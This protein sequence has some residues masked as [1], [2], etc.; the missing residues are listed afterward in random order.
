MQ[1]EKNKSKRLSG[2]ISS[3]VLLAISLSIVFLAAAVYITQKTFSEVTK[4]IEQLS[5][6]DAKTAFL[7]GVYNAFG[8][9]ER[10][11]QSRLL[12]DP[13]RAKD[14][15]FA[16]L[17]SL[18]FVIDSTSRQYH[19]GP[20]ERL[21]L[22]SISDMIER[23]NESLLKFRIMKRNQQPI[24]EQNLDSL[25]DLINSERVVSQSDVITTLKSTRILPT[26]TE[27][28]N[29]EEARD[30]QSQKT[31]LQ[32]IFS[33]GNEEIQPEIA[34]QNP[35]IIEETYIRIDTV[36]L[37]S[38]D[39]SIAKAGQLI[40]KIERK[41]ASRLRMINRV[42]MDIV[43]LGA[44][45]Q[46][47][48]LALIRNSEE[49]ELLRIH[50]ES[51]LANT[52]MQTAISRM[53]LVFGIFAILAILFVGRILNDLTKAKSYR[54]QLIEEKVRAENLSKIKERFLANM[55]HEIRTPLQNISGYS[56][57]LSKKQNSPD[58]EII[59]QS[60]NH[61]LQIVNQVLDFSRISTGNLI[62]HPKVFSITKLIDEVVSS[63]KIQAV[64]KNIRLISQTDCDEDRVYADPF[65]IRQILYNLLG[66]AIK[67]TGEGF[68]KLSAQSEKKG[69][70]IRVHFSIEDTGIG[71][72][73]NEIERL[74]K[75]FEQADTLTHAT[76][77]TGLGLSI[78]KA[79]VE[80][81]K[82]SIT[83]KS[84]E[85]RGTKFDVQLAL[86]TIPEVEMGDNN[87]KSIKKMR[88][89]LLVDDD[90]SILNLTRDILIENK[91]DVVCTTSPREAIEIAK[92]QT[93]DIALVDYRM[94]EMTG[95]ELC[96][97]L[98][99]IDPKMPVIAVTANPINPSG[100]T[101]DFDGYFPKPYR[102][103]E[104]LALLGY[105]DVDTEISDHKKVLDKK[106]ATITM[107]EKAAQE[108]LINQF[109][110]DSM[111]DVD[112]IENEL[113]ADNTEQ[114]RE[115]A[116]RIAGR[117]GF[118]E[119][120]NLASQFRQVEKAIED[121]SFTPGSKVKLQDAIK[122]LKSRIA[123]ME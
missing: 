2:S 101:T 111:N 92:N 93:F 14:S 59:H 56:E 77:G 87:S 82:G 24:L 100:E 9:F 34:Q 90:K 110:E 4:T 66:N 42:E 114:I 49:E 31:W 35:K 120:K 86:E 70:Q 80:E 1:I 28:Q 8:N 58:A 60:S 89:V 68:V 25:I 12:A 57:R 15:Y 48:I 6:A 118:F 18:K 122:E 88:R 21:I 50:T 102:T 95:A 16:S 37:A 30:D 121:N 78:V 47:F 41:Q 117:L 5:E 67:F 73:K 52:L 85:G 72:D 55:S 97:V 63:M 107:G 61:L 44:R 43:S 116:H 71:M 17:D 29:T 91:I 76:N 19:F 83:V 3:M 99:E 46:N 20:T 105:T 64:D 22:D 115:A 79:L 108:E 106:L 11:Q 103:H 98:K 23:Q 45:I 62:L 13:S 112:W 33:S 96:I 113:I 40:K 51:R 119:F 53:Y 104:L 26:P 39:T 65:R 38:N 84:D 75:E 54:R 32:R 27:T 7:N 123:E 94:P 81:Y 10:N 36:P 69:N 109:K 74:F